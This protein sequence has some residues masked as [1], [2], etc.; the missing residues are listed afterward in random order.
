MTQKPIGALAARIRNSIH[1][2]YDAIEDRHVAFEGYSEEGITI[3][4]RL[5]AAVQIVAD[6]LSGLDE[7][8]RELQ[9]AVK[10]DER[11]YAKA[12]RMLKQEREEVRKQRMTLYKEWAEVHQLRCKLLADHETLKQIYTGRFDRLQQGWDQL[13][14][15]RKDAIPNYALRKEA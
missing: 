4:E 7:V 9:Q 13:A 14:Q 10:R 3:E 2:L 6:T 5:D 8:L 11:D 15:Y 12:Y 1:E